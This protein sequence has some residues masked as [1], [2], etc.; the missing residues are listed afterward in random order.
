MNKIN[1]A[2]L[3]GGDSSEKEI[4]LQSAARVSESIDTSK[5]NV[6]LINISGRSWTYLSKEGTEIQVDKNDFSLTVGSQKI[7]FDYALIL[8]HGTPGENGKM[9]GYLDMMG[10]S[11][12][13]CDLTSTVVTFDKLL[14][15]IAVKESGVNLAKHIYIKSGDKVDP[16]RLVAEL[17]LPLIIKPTASGSS[18]GVTKVR[19]ADEIPTA[20]ENAR[21]ESANVLAE[22]FIAGMEVSCG[23]L[24]TKKKEYVL[25]ITEIVPKKDFFDYEAKYMPGFSE[26][27][28]PARI[29]EKTKAVVNEMTR[30]V[31]KACGCRGV[32]RV[33]FII[34]DGVPY[35]IEVNSIPGM[36]GGSIVPKQA[37]VI[38]LTLGELYD[39]IIE[40]TYTPR[41]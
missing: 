7:I 36:S 15:K 18:F 16:E 1:I 21:K 23:I 2:L 6:Y 38:G 35:F 22:E 5:Y 12:S 11:Y 29:D 40:D 33:D 27:I 17:G 8:I 37:S 14:C 10:V 32:V 39:M 3:A 41:R 30:N 28:T 9:Q 31:Y 19:N 13:S 34:K 20:I 26:E 25:P 4:S 24:I